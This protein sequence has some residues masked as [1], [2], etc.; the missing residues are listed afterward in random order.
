MLNERTIKQSLSLNPSILYL[1][2]QDE[3]F[4]QAKAK[5][6]ERQKKLREIEEQEKTQNTSL[7]VQS[8]TSTNATEEDDDGFRAPRSSRSLFSL[9]WMNGGHTN[10]EEGSKSNRLT[11]QMLPPLEG[12]SSSKTAED[13][14]PMSTGR[15]KKQ[16]KMKN[17]VQSHDV[18]DN[19]HDAYGQRT[20]SV[21]RIQVESVDQNND[22]DSDSI[23]Q[24]S[25]RRDPFRKS[26]GLYIDESKGH[27]ESPDSGS[28]KKTRK[29]KPQVSSDGEEGFDTLRLSQ[30]LENDIIDQYSSPRN[31]S[32]QST[33]Q[34]ELTNG[35]L[36]YF[37]KLHLKQ[38]SVLVFQ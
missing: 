29:K 30:H 25:G 15:G 28:K 2:Q 13:G 26:K 32:R 37:V 18:V 6:K 23:I 17:K 10:E 24:S 12:L 38:P 20:S 19:D 27:H 11:R 16:K 4:K 3:K 7:K 9:G 21:S 14:S 35:K 5:E 1:S 36:F 31:D 33:P 34:K 8:N 22:D